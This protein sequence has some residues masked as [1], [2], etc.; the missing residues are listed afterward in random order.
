M[1]NQKT[2]L[3]FSYF[4]DCDGDSLEL[5][6]E[7]GFKWKPSIHMPKDAARIWLMLEDIR[8]QR[9]QDITEQDAIAEGIL[10]ID[11]H[12][13]LVWKRYDENA[14]VTSSPI[15]SFWSL[16]SSINGEDSWQHNPWVWVVKFRVLSTTGRPSIK[17][18]LEAH[19]DI[20]SEC[21]EVSHA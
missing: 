12:G 5:A 7:Y 18:I 17:Q 2:A 6:K 21:K 14:T 9:L 20:T 16:W 3:H 1:V 10:P 19:T 8:P 13:Q 15:V 11:Q 4:S